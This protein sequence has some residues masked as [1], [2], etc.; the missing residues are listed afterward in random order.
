M[1]TDRHPRIRRVYF[2][3]AAL[4]YDLGKELYRKL[5]AVVPEVAVL[6]PRGRVPGGGTRSA[7]AESYR[8]AKQTLVV[9][10]RRDLSF[11]KCRPSADWQLPLVTSCPGLCAYC[12]LQT[13]LG[14]RPYM[15]VYVNIDEILSKADDY[16]G[17]AATPVERRGGPGATTFEAAATGDPIAVETLTGALSRV[18]AAFGGKTNALLRVVT[19][20]AGVEPLLPID[21]G[22]RTRVRFSINTPHVASRWEG[23]T[24]PVE[25]RLEAAVRV[26]AAGYPIG[27]MV[28]PVILYPSWRDDYGR[29][30]EEARARM[31]AGGVR[32]DLAGADGKGF[33]FEVVTHR[34][35]AR[36]RDLIVS[37]HA[38]AGLPMEEEG[39][40]YR[41][42]QFGYGKWVYPGDE[43]D[44]V[45]EF[46]SISI[47]RLFPEATLEYVV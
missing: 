34:F 42:G 9:A 19:K 47:A 23:G 39:R 26:A 37:R 33:T 38:G 35:T 12:Y 21:H 13:T 6:P 3:A 4:E 7:P 10:V 41:M 29:L 17:G 25:E 14:A 28:A 2:E 31:A 15:R 30:L 1:V 45:K 22:G 36:A 16:A 18:I 27:L 46:M 32:H 44:D 43:M 5:P 24:S 11:Q 8:A 40:R 20:F